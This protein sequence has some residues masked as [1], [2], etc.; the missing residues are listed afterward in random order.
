MGKADRLALA[1]VNKID[2]TGWEDL[3][4]RQAHMANLVK[5]RIFREPWDVDRRLSEMHLEKAKLLTVR[6]TAIGAA[7]DA[8]RFHPAN[9]AGTFSYQ[10]GTFSL[11]N[12]H[13]GDV[14]LLDRPNGVEAIRNESDRLKI[15]FANVDI[16]CHDTHEPKPRLRTHCQSQKMTVAAMQMAEKKVWAHRS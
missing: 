3:L 8:T 11:R 13:V 1:H 9:A 12:E 5:T 15:V 4:T 14:W 16:A 10:Y 7:A 2:H 6:S